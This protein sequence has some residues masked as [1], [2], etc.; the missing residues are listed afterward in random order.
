MLYRL[1]LRAPGE[2]GALPRGQNAIIHLNEPGIS[3]Q[4][5][6]HNLGNMFAS[7]FLP[8]DTVQ[9]FLLAAMGIWAADKLVS[10]RLARDAWT[11][12]LELHLPVTG[13]WLTLASRL[14]KLL[15]FLTGD[16]WTL[17]C[18]EFPI[19]LGFAGKWPCAWQPSAVA[20][21]SGGLDSLVGAI[22][23]L[24]AGD[25]LL[26]VSHYDYGQ[27]AA[28]QQAL[29]AALSRHYGPERLQHLAVRVS[30][31][32]FQE[33]TL[34]SRSLLYLALGLAAAAAFG[35]DM[36]LV[37]PENGWISFNPPLTLNRLGTYSTRTTH[38]F[39]LRELSDLWTEVGL[40]HPLLNPYQYQSK[41]E[42]LEN[43]R[44]SPLLKKLIPLTSSCAHPVAS[45]WQGEPE[46][47]CGYCYP[48]LLRRAALNRLGWDDG[49]H[50]RLDALSH[51]D[52]LRHRQKGADLRALLL[53]IQT[54][55][56]NP[57][58]VLARLWLGVPAA[59]V[60]ARYYPA[61]PLLTAGF[62][63]LAQFFQDKGPP[64]IRSYLNW[65]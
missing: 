1:Y 54:W 20:L 41:G 42:V 9:A 23:K 63:E 21:F 22:D 59:A 58:E 55:S 7:P 17:N 47:E 45:R 32:E 51:P 29:A 49:G 61:R 24:E 36:P 15:S 16:R 50:Y 3:G 60:P 31:P 57:Q 48:C 52:I 40:R 19:N 34:R 28:R 37:V 44:N 62:Q 64:W 43:C 26:L 56:H 11:R 33:I 13:R 39:F 30:F 25:R 27:L 38:P 6:H 4:P 18:R 65:P 10:R 2:K 53:A 5:V 35:P 14:S 8:P 46:G 12:V